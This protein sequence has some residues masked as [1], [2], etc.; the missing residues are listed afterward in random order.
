MVVTCAGNLSFADTLTCAKDICG[1]MLGTQMSRAVQGDRDAFKSDAA[2][3]RKSPTAHLM[4]SGL[5]WMSSLPI[6]MSNSFCSTITPN[7]LQRPLLSE[8]CP[9]TQSLL[10]MAVH[11]GRAVWQ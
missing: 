1:A 2:P 6:S 4:F 9:E 11:A 3:G 10:P 7:L 5:D 8:P